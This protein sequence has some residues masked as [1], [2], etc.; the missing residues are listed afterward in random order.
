MSSASHCSWARAALHWS[1]CAAKVLHTQ[2][3][4]VCISLCART[5]FGV[6][7]NNVGMGPQWCLGC[8]LLTIVMHCEARTEGWGNPSHPG[9]GCIL[10]AMLGCMERLKVRKGCIG[11]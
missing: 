10:D 9:F 2:C 5:G 8:A 6:A 7:V 4:L 3:V 11:K 1:P